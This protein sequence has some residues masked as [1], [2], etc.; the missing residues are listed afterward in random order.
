MSEWIKCSECDGL[1]AICRALGT[2]DDRLQETSAASVL[3]RYEGRQ[4]EVVPRVVWNHCWACDG[5]GVSF[6]S[7]HI[8]EIL[9][10]STEQLRRAIADRQGPTRVVCDPPVGWKGI[11]ER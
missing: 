4:L 10:G 8:P 2:A 11:I 5:T 7:N 3:A 9:D 1:G 6:E